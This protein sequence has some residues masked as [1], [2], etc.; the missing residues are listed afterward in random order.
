MEQGRHISDYANQAQSLTNKFTE[1]RNLLSV[2]STFPDVDSDSKE[3]KRSQPE[4]TNPRRVS[5]TLPGRV[6]GGQGRAVLQVQ[7]VEFP[8][9]RRA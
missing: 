6:E 1:G 5:A 7:P 9:A 2:L 3:K 4:R 8:E